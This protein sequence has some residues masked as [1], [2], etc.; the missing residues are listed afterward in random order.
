[1]KIMAIKLSSAQR[2]V[3]RSWRLRLS[4][5]LGLVMPLLR[6]G[7]SSGQEE[8]QVGY[9]HMLYQEDNNRIRVDTDS[10]YWDVGLSPHVRLNGEFVFDSISGATPT[11]A[12]PQSQWPF[13][14]YNYYYQVAY[15]PAYN[16]LFN[17]YIS[18]NLIN[19]EYGYWTYQQLTN[20]A[21]QYAQTRS[22]RRP[23]RRRL[24]AKMPALPMPP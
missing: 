9:R 7:R 21:T 24:P 2:G 20:N 13:P 12:P 10:A 16:G 4:R 18:D 17:R 5:A 14:P 11:G 15:A 22:M 23:A 8:D 3:R 1:M 19:A 6:A